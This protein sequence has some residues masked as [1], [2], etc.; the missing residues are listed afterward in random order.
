MFRYIVCLF[1]IAS[2]V[3][4]ADDIQITPG[5]FATSPNRKYIATAAMRISLGK[6]DGIVLLDDL[7]KSTQSTLDEGTFYHSFEWLDDKTLYATNFDGAIIWDVESGKERWLIREHDDISYGEVYPSPSGKFFA[8]R[9]NVKN[10]PNGIL[11][12]DKSGTVRHRIPQKYKLFLSGRLVWDDTDSHLY[13]EERPNIDANAFF[14]FDLSKPDLPPAQLFTFQEPFG[15]P[16]SYGLQF[17]ATPRSLIWDSKVF[18][19]DLILDLKSHAVGPLNEFDRHDDSFVVEMLTNRVE[20][21]AMLTRRSS[22]KFEI[23]VSMPHE[24]RAQG[25]VLICD[26]G[27]CER[28]RWLDERTIELA[29]YHKEKT[30][31]IWIDVNSQQRTTH[32]LESIRKYK[33]TQPKP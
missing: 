33:A 27:D 28:F 15:V 17:L 2:S 23:R 3:L 16:E 31:I 18:K 1:A 19:R 8:V 9:E 14:D 20:Q 29:R 7:T 4:S 21:I 22:G 11:I 10:E 25:S 24:L 6:I 5:R 26:D 12:L 30:E 13:F 32:F